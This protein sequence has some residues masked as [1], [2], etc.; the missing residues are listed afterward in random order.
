MSTRFLKLRR[1]HSGFT[2]VEILVALLIL[3]IMA[4]LGILDLPCGANLGGAHAR[5]R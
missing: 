5:I 4:G 2:L 3:A 1:V